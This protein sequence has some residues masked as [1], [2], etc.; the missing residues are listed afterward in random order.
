MWQAEI[1]QAQPFSVWMCG[2]GTCCCWI[3]TCLTLKHTGA[4]S[5]KKG[6][7]LSMTLPAQRLGRRTS[8]NNRPAPQGEW[9][10]KADC[11][12]HFFW[13]MWTQFSIH[14]FLNYFQSEF[15]H[16]SAITVYLC[17][18]AQ[19]LATQTNNFRPGFSLAE[20]E[21]PSME[22][23]ATKPMPNLKLRVG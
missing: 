7:A 4:L 12:H 11:T 5:R 1:W 6:A 10:C 23:T 18:A 14:H 16:L 19:H 13:I 8:R 15:S 2:R 17:F 20:A 3:S 22:P 21:S 9:D